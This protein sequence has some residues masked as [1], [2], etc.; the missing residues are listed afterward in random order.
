MMT[1]QLVRGLEEAE[2]GK[3]VR[4]FLIESDWNT[5]DFNFPGSDIP[6]VDKVLLAGLERLA[7]LLGWDPGRVAAQLAE[8]TRHFVAPV[9][10]QQVADND[11]G[12]PSVER[13]ETR[14]VHCCNDK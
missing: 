10:L 7:E 5:A 6:D 8:N 9:D 4:R 14:M 12:L 11:A 2:P 3:G 1:S 13:K